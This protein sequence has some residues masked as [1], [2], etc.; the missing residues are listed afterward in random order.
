M[1][2]AVRR[3]LVSDQVFRVLSE[4]ILS[5][6]YAPAEKLPTQRRLAA[7]LGVNMASIRE[8]VKRL[9][10]LRLVEVRHGDAMRVTSWRAEGGLDVI[11][12][13]LL[14]GGTLDRGTLAAIMEARRLM[15]S[16][17]ARLAAGRR[18][19]RQA[20]ALVELAERISAAAEAEAAQAL[21]FAFFSE[22]VEAAGNVVF[23]L[24]MNSIRQLY[25]QQAELF[26]AVVAEHRELAPLY[27]EAAAAVERR[28]GAGAAAAVEQVADAQEARLRASLDQRGGRA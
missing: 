10:Q 24:V 18:E 23:V 19:D 3:A 16:E 28:D 12:H 15:L 21:D 9:E 4:E 26:R 13:V 1:A 27:R 11:A 17:V 25:F 7:D 8:A 6:R 20:A 22:M 14:R 2:L 5:G